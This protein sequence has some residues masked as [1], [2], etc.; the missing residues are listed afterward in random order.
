MPDCSYV[1][2]TRQSLLNHEGLSLGEPRIGPWIQGFMPEGFLQGRKAASLGKMPVSGSLAQHIIR[3]RL[4]VAKMQSI[5]SNR[6]VGT[7]MPSLI[8]PVTFIML[9]R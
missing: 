5:A 3:D 1:L 2:T 6:R 4:S 8:H 9:Q 7:T